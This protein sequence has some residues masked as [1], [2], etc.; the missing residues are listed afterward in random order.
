MP[1]ADVVDYPKT[2]H[3][4]VAETAQAVVAGTLG[5]IEAAR[6]FVGLAAEL[7]ALEDEEFSFFLDVDTQSDHFPLGSA[8][9]CWS[10]VALR[11]EDLVRGEY[12]AT[13]RE[14]AL[15]HC[16][17]LIAKYARIA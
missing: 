12:E 13:I 9:E 2:L 10:P 8:R 11:R 15:G 6:R 5:P 16:R 3:R 14:A 17:S 1:S 7:G 4:A